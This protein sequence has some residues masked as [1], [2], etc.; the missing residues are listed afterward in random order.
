LTEAVAGAGADVRDRVHAVAR[1]LAHAAPLN[2]GMLAEIDTRH[3]DTTESARLHE[4][5]YDSLRLPIVGALEPAARAGQLAQDDLD[6]CAMALV[7]LVQS[8]HAIPNL[9]SVEARESLALQLA[10]ML[11]DGWLRR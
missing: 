6:L 1:W 10:D 8:V 9:T 4:L 11:L 5:L 2:M 3:L 7:S